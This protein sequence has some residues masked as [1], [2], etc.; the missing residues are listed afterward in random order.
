MSSLSQFQ[1]PSI[2]LRS[3]AI[4]RTAGVFCWRW[5]LRVASL[6]ISFPWAVFLFL[7]FTR[8]HFTFADFLAVCHTAYGSVFPIIV[9]I[10]G[11]WFGWQFPVAA[12]YRHFLE[13]NDE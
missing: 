10:S 6:A 7:F 1:V 3:W 12:W 9:F 2:F 11:L 4:V 5:T 13:P 8:S